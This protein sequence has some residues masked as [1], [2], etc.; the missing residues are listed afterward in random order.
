MKLE[1]TLN[2]RPRTMEADGS[3]R[4]LDFI[5]VGRVTGEH[6]RGRWANVG[7]LEELER[8]ERLFGN[9]ADGKE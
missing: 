2:G 7:S 4:L 8:A 1:F 5:R 6:Y 3:K 9:S